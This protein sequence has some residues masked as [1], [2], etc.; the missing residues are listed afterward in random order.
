MEDRGMMQ[1]RRHGETYRLNVVLIPML[2]GT[3]CLILCV[4]VLAYDLFVAPPFSWQKFLAFVLLLGGYCLVSWLVL[5]Q[6]YV[7]IKKRDISL[8]FLV[9]DLL[10]W[11][12]TVYRTGGDQSLLFF[13]GI[14]RVADQA[15]TTFKRVLMFAHLT[16]V[17]YALLILYLIFV[18]GRPVDLR[19]ELVKMVFIYGANM[20]LAITSRPAEAFRKRSTH[21][22][23]QARRL[24]SPL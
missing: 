4:Y 21:A 2:R 8:F 14:V 9:T 22:A 12:F 3:G 11:L 24:N 18:E 7:R 23:R 1:R 5:S 16:V 10:L 17:A 20:Y 6:A 19:L 15:Y 13:L